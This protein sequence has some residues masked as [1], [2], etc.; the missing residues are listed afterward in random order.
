VS[1]HVSREPGAPGPVL[2][3]DVFSLLYRAFFALPPMNTQAGEPTNAL[4]GFAAIVLK[5]LRE[6]GGARASFAI[7]RPEPTFRHAAFAGYKRSRPVAPTPLGQ[8]VA[9]LPELLEAFGFPL[10][11]VPGYEADDVLATLARGLRATGEAP[12]IVSGDLDLLQC[13]INPARVHVVGRGTQSRTYAEA[14][15]WARFGVAPGELP[16]WKALAGDVTDEIPGVPGIGAKTASALVRRFG[17]VANLVARIE[18]VE[19]A[20]LR[21]AIA[22][23]VPELPLWGDLARL[24][25]DVPLPAGARW[26]HFDP[27]AQART[28]DRFVAL[29]FRSLQPRLAALAAGAGANETEPPEA[30]PE[31]VEHGSS[32]TRS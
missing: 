26:A 14:D 11:A 3:F 23:A 5:L 28:R 21:R 18:E 30:K 24:H 10:F 1:E 6:S 9:R 17:S 31:V 16:E 13:A 12:L 20:S 4:Y 27:A 22:A 32:R 15:V 29:E 7:D 19:P 2:L 25:D 8:Q